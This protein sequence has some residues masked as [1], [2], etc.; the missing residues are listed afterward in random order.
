M[1]AHDTAA[2]AARIAAQAAGQ[3]ALDAYKREDAANDRDID[4]RERSQ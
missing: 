3:L 2:Y 4:E 1:T